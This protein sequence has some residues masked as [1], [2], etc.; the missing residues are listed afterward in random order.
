MLTERQKRILWAVIDDYIL[1]AEPVGSRTVSRKDGVGFSAATVRNEMADLEEMGYLEQPH[2]SAGRIPSQ[3]GYRF[4][5]DH[6]VTPQIWNKKELTRLH[7]FFSSTTGTDHLEEVIQHTSGLLSQMTN[8]MGVVMGPKFEE[9][10]LKHLQIVPI[11]ERLAVAILVT[12]SGHVEQRKIVVPDG[13]TV[14]S[15]EKLVNFLNFRLQGIPL[16]QLSKRVAMDY[17]EELKYHLDQLEPILLMMQQIFQHSQEERLFMSGA[18]RMLDQPEFQDVDKLKTILDL[19]EENNTMIHLMEPTIEGVQVR[20]GSELSLQEM[21]H[22]SFISASYYYQGEAVGTIGV[23]GPT[24]M[25]Y[26]R[27]IGLI[28]LMSKDFSNRLN[29]LVD[30]K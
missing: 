25:N 9:S 5:V 23:L 28:D 3:K 24:R 4:F 17:Q 20:I 29:V 13:V 11:T 22:M 10:S 7:E 26:A 15:M 8:Y 6:L 2:T 21:D 1:T 19:I 14:Q 18:T 16:R 30:G 12:N 27:V